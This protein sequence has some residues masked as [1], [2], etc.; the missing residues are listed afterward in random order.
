MTPPSTAW[1][2]IAQD[3]TDRILQGE[4]PVGAKIPSH[5]ELSER[6]GT[7][8]GTVKR[9]VDHLREAG[10]LQGV[11]GAGVFVRRLPRKEDLRFESTASQGS[12]EQ[13]NLRAELNE[14]RRRVDSL[15]RA[16]QAPAQKAEAPDEDLRR[17][18]GLLQAHVIELYGRL[19]QPYPGTADSSKGRLPRRNARRAA[20]G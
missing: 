14:I 10:V 8:V 1:Q 7:S 5:Q 3:I 16:R 12:E 19:G 11:Q 17:L 9:A 13:E 2:R 15:E 4:T 20:E 18:V 6:H